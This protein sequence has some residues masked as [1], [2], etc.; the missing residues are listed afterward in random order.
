MSE[1]RSTG[2]AKR[3]RAYCI[4]FRGCRQGLLV[5]VRVT[6]RAVI[7]KQVRQ[8][9]PAW[10]FTFVSSHWTAKTLTEK[11]TSIFARNLRT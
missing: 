6:C 11:V 8:Q 2:I 9:R 4:C 7:W 3:V 1:H 5:Y 10:F